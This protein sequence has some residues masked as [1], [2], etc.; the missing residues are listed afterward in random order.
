VPSSSG[1]RAH[2]WP[3]TGKD[4]GRGHPHVINMGEV[5]HALHLNLIG[6]C[7]AGA[8]FLIYKE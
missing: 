1:S 3:K 6:A 7:E 5:L 4:S 2:C 8:S